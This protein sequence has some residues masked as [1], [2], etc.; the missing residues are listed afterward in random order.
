MQAGAKNQYELGQWLGKRYQSLFAEAYEENK[1]EILSSNFNRTI[2]SAEI[3]L[4]GIFSN[5]KG[6]DFEF[7]EDTLDIQTIP[8][9]K[10]HLVKNN[11]SCAKLDELY[12][13]LMTEEPFRMNETLYEH[14]RNFT[15]SNICSLEKAFILY[16]TLRT[17]VLHNFTLPEW[18]KEVYPDVLKE[19][20]LHYFLS[21]THTKEIARLKVGPLWNKILSFFKDYVSSP[22]GYPRVFIISGH[23][24]TLV[25]LLNS[26]GAFD[27]RLPSFSSC[28]VFELRRSIDEEDFFVETYFKDEGDFKKV[29]FQNCSFK[30]KLNDVGTSLESILVTPIVWE[31]E[32]NPM[33]PPYIGYLICGIGVG[34]LVLT[35]KSHSCYKKYRKRKT[36]SA[37]YVRCPQ[38]Q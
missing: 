23:E 22:R 21:L 32:C 16:D 24:F 38:K 33:G 36:E 19:E 25:N 34:L 4:R 2:R 26:I 28:I 6:S 14:L 17:E 3:T 8:D 15:Q 5:M 31:D 13:E 27:Q 20:A 35:L 37:S 10:D 11:V 12:A 9:E 1:I 30:C 7:N 29:R 18:T